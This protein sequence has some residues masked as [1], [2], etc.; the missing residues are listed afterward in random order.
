MTVEE[1]EQV[2]RDLR[3]KPENL[4]KENEE[5]CEACLASLRSELEKIHLKDAYNLALLERCPELVGRD[6][7]Q[8]GFLRADRYDAK[9]C[10]GSKSQP[11]IFRL[12]EHL[13]LVAG[14]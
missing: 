2:E 4:P 6:S 3:G 13:P 5:F 9:V 11:P 10:S 7:F 1:K 14:G 8:M 12:S